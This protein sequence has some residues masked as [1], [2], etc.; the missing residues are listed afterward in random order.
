M[1][2]I[3]QLRSL[4]IGYSLGYG[5]QKLVAEAINQNLH[6]GEITCLLGRNGAG[7]STLIRTISGFQPPL[8]GEILINGKNLYK[9]SENERAQSVGVVLTDRTNAGGITVFDLIALGRHPH[10][11][12][13]GGLKEK[14]KAEIQASMEKVGI[15]EKSDAYVSEL[16]DGER[17][18]AMIA[19]ALAQECPIILLDEP[20]AFL[21]INS[22]IE[23]MELLRNLTKKEKKC[24]LL[25]THD[26]ESAVRMADNFWLMAKKYPFTSGSPEEL[27]SSG[28]FDDF[29][30]LS[31]SSDW[32][33]KKYLI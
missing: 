31:T 14:D 25:S 32:S 4:S 29:F 11:G 19:K 24:V 28:V 26:V 16:S 27:I 12:F 20:T 8:S 10:T 33:A 15:V 23:T 6:E 9:L 1:K 3:I 18:K 22:R 17:Q 13:F 30:D 2:A 7:K 5:K 21:D